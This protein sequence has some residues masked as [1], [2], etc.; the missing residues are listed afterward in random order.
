MRSKLIT[1]AIATGALGAGVLVAAA[2]GP[3]GANAAGGLLASVPAATSPSTA[4]S[5]AAATAPDPDGPPM[6]RGPGGPGRRHLAAA[7]TALGIDEATLRAALESGKSIADVATENKVDLAKVITALVDDEKSELAARVTSGEIT[8]AQAD[9]RL[10]G[11]TDRITAQVNRAGLVGPGGPGGF[12]GRGH[13]G[14]G[15]PGGHLDL[16]AAAKALGTDA[17]TLRTELSSGKSIADVATEKKVDLAKVVTAIVDAEKAELAV[18][19]TNG[20]LTQAQAD[21]RLAGLT[22]RVTAAVKQ[23]RTAGDCGPDGGPDGGPDAAPDQ[24]PG[25]TTAPA[26]AASSSAGVTS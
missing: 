16:A 22:D 20:D 15:G 2:L 3:V 12:G 9:Q 24:A 17:A 26:P 4:P 7:A 8:Q 6:G 18:R 10:A 11:L 1:G 19:V 5:T 23:V 13:G 25:G 21:Q 14:R